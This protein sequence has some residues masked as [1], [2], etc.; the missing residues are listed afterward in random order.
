MLT[1]PFFP[2]SILIRL[3]HLRELL[4]RVPSLPLWAELLW[5]RQHQEQSP[6]L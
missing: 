3:H 4:G 1:L 5:V 6:P 2:L